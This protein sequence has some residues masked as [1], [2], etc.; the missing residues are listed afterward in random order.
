MASCPSLT[1]KKNLPTPLCSSARCT[2]KRFSSESSAIK[3]RSPGLICCPIID[4]PL[5]HEA[6]AV[7]AESPSDCEP[8]PVSLIVQALC[9]EQKPQ[10]SL[11]FPLAA[12]DNID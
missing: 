1:P 4:I 11:R 7:P 10:D 2:K 3:I 12:K 9:S 5:N 8:P 6:L